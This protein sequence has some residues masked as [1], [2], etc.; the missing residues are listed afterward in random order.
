[1]GKQIMAVSAGLRHSLAITGDGKVWSWGSGKRG[2]LGRTPAHGSLAESSDKPEMV[3]MPDGVRCTKVAAGAYHSAALS[4]KDKILKSIYF[5]NKFW[6][7]GSG[8]RGRLGRT[9]AFST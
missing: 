8:K 9:L 1:M 5:V 7:W 3:D 2:Q 4:G 6:S